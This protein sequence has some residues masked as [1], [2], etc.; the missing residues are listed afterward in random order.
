[1]QILPDHVR[2]GA[3]VSV[4]RERWRVVDVRPLGDCQVVT[5]S[6]LSPAHMGVEKRVLAPFEVFDPLAGAGRPRVVRRARWRRAFRALLATAAP[7]A[8]LC[9]ARHARI[10]LL[11]H[12]LEPAMAVLRG[13]GSRVLLADEVGLGKTIQTG[14]VLAELFARAAIDRALVI[15][16]AGLRDQWSHELASRFGMTPT[17]VD[18]RVLRQRATMLP[19]GVNPWSTISLAI[20]SIDYV[21]RPE[22]LPAVAACA[23]D[24][25]VIDEAHGVAGDSE[26]RDAV[27]T[28]ASGALYVLLL[29]ATPHSGDAAAFTALCDLGSFNDDPL[30]LFRRTRSS[31]NLGV[32]RHV[33][34]LHVRLGPIERRMHEQLWRY[35]NAVR[36]ERPSAWL[37]LA[38]L[39]KRALSGAWALA[40]SVDRRIAA[41]TAP[42][43]DATDRQLA[44]PLDDPGGEF[45]RADEPPSWPAGIGLSDAARERD[46]LTALVAAARSAARDESKL[47]ALRRLL[48]RTGETAIV[49]TEYRDTLLH[50]RRTLHAAS[51]RVAVLHGGLTQAE[52]AA[53]LQ[54]FTRGACAVLL[55]TDAAGEG[56]NLHEA[57]RLV[58]N[59]ELPWNPMRLEQRIGRVDRIGQ[60]RTVHAFHLIARG[61]GEQAIAARLR[62]RI[63]RAQADV[64]APN[65]L[66][67]E[68]ERAS[69]WLAMTGES[70]GDA[71]DDRSAS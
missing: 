19:L 22:V 49:F 56:L 55:A 65:P 67:A 12:Q 27:R 42:D 38:V 52:R 7:P 8:S 69:A 71:P 30:L 17:P 26:R 9:S 3:L 16:P 46:L 5:L 57:C 62:A 21:K 63:A 23:W 40:R 44:L 60:R 14:L 37:G 11:P 51:G 2:P 18:A 20:A 43:P 31:I 1:M 25:I 29:T 32:A 33:H 39:H 4:R 35:S 59:L 53:V 45:T 61:T 6:G 24:A 54:D 34:S 41:L 47:S 15:P 48:R 70:N 66:G 13:L 28:L 50:V 36:A 64:G 58:I 68:E 10:D